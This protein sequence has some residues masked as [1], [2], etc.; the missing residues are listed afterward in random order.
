M[1]INPIH[2]VKILIINCLCLS[3]YRVF[4]QWQMTHL[5]LVFNLFLAWLPYQLSTLV[6]KANRTYLNWSL[7]AITLLFLPNAAYL[8]TDLVH[9]RSSNHINL[10]YDLVLFFSYALTGLT[11]TMYSVEQLIDYLK[12]NYGKGI[13]RIFQ[14]LVFPLIGTGIYLGRIERFNSWDV[15]THPF[16]FCE[17]LIHLVF[18]YKCL[19]MLQFTLLF[20]LFS[21]LI[22]WFFHHVRRHHSA[23]TIKPTKY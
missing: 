20:G 22:Y 21:G 16:A 12:D 6:G 18:S 7:F 14:I 17:E 15:V 3:A 8:L 4:D 1:K 9:Y 23:I 11:L 5:F 19:E 13:T 2:P 10:W